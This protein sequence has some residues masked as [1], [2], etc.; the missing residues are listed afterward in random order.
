MD[1]V[2]HSAF[3]VI[4]IDWAS[5]IGSWLGVLAGRYRFRA[6]YARARSNY[7]RLAPGAPSEQEAD[8]AMTRLWGHLGRVMAEFSTL[9]RLWA[10]G[11]IRVAGGEHLAAARAAGKP[12]LVIGLHLGNWEV[13]GPALIGMG[14]PVSGIYQPPRSRFEE[15]IAVA[16]RRR[17][18]AVP[19]R[20]GIAATRK[21]Y[22]VLVDDCGLL[23]FFVDEEQRGEV[24]APLFGRPLRPRANLASA[25]R[26]AWASGAAVIPAY[27][28]RLKGAR[29]VIN[30]LPPIDLVPA[31]PHNPDAALENVRRLDRLITPIVLGRLDQWYWMPHLRLN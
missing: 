17:Y 13:I 15:T 23:L 10:A 7:L 30:F 29:F 11:R 28:E 16:S 6:G 8:V 12:I 14:F 4:P 26:F 31:D 1:I 9:D 18:G 5:A 2:L 3:R 22:R 19:L 20:A 27:S 21:A 25:V 24:N